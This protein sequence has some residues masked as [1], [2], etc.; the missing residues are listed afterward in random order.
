[1][2][3]H[4]RLACSCAAQAANRG[5][6][7]AQPAACLVN[8]EL[9]VPAAQM[10]WCP[11]YGSVAGVHLAGGTGVQKRTCFRRGLVHALQLQPSRDSAL[12]K[13]R[14]PA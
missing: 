8:R 7:I 14:D 12:G 11:L 4:R 2:R 5:R 9:V 10:P 3:R 6:C 1:M 13:T